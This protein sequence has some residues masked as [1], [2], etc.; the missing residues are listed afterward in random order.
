MT[1]TA[2]GGPD[3]EGGK[4][5][6]GHAGAAATGPAPAGQALAVPLAVRG[7][8]LDDIVSPILKILLIVT[9]FLGG[10]EYLQRQQSARVEKSLQLVDQ[11]RSGGHRDAYQR[12]ND[13]V[14]PLFAQVA[15]K[16]S[17]DQR[18]LILANIGETVTGRDDDFSSQADKDT[19]SVFEFFE[20]AALCANERI[21]DYDV[22]DTF[23][24]QEVK[25]FWPYFSRYAEHRRDLG[26]VSYG[27]WTQRFAEGQIRRAILGLF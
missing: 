23:L 14:A 16:V 24:G 5:L 8:Q 21:C 18:L 2:A 7:K 27:L 9:V 11:W 22:L 19:D 20:R 13:L 12:I 1:S 26:Y 3:D 17:D 15:G 10:Y 25:S 6:P 4:A